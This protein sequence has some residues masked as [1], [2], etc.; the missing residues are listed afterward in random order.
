M[1][2]SFKQTLRRWALDAGITS[3]AS[4][5]IKGVRM[6]MH[7]GVGEGY[8]AAALDKQIAWLKARH[9]IMAFHEVATSLRQGRSLPDF[10]IVLTF[11]DGLRNNLTEAYPVLLKHQAP[12][13][14][15]VCPALIDAG[16]WI[17]TYEVRE[18]LKS[19]SQEQLR[20]LAT[21]C[22]GKACDTLDAFVSWMKKQPNAGRLEALE[23]VRSATSSFE[24]TETHRRE[25]D[26]ASWDELAALD[27]RLITIGSHTLSHPILSSLAGGELDN[28]L[29]GSKQALLAKGLM[30]EDKAFLCYPDGNHDKRV[31]A[32]AE[33]HYSAACSTRKGLIASTSPVFAMPRIGANSALE[34]VAWRLWRPAA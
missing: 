11:D 12:A 27:N 32:C 21:R 8:D 1:A 23:A 10:A 34:D 30:T 24:I 18:R 22:S 17:W 33:R 31:L 19:L 5:R 28:E 26:L 16:Q 15:F 4:R 9:P 25:Y 13:T 14:F 2:S 3:L 29:K 7:H 6:L 20:A